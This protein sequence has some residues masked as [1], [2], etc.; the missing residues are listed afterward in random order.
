MKACLVLLARSA[1]VDGSGDPP[2]AWLLPTI[3]VGTD[4]WKVGEP[5]IAGVRWDY[6]DHAHPRTCTFIVD[7]TCYDGTLYPFEIASISCDGCT[8]TEQSDGVGEYDGYAPLVVTPSVAG[9]FTLDVE[10]VHPKGRRESVR[11]DARAE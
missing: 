6:V 10:I 4:L 7:F 5:R 9:P 2:P 8:A 3:D 11:L 1:C